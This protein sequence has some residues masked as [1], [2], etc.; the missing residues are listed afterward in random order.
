MIRE[1]NKMNID[2]RVLL[3]KVDIKIKHNSLLIFSIIWF[4]RFYL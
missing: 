4:S 1:E 3:H 2:L